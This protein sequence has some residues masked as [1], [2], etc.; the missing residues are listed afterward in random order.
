MKREDLAA[1]GLTDEQIEK[2]IA[3]NG[4][5][6]QTANAKATKNNAELERLQGIE[7]EFNAMKDQNLSEQE[8][9]AKQLEEA[10]KRIAE[11][12]K[13]QTLATQR[14]NAADK[15]KITSEQAAKVVKD[16]GSFDFDVLG[17]IISDKETAAAQAKE[18]EIANGST[19]P[20]GG[21]AGGGKNDTKTEAE[22]AAEKIGKT[23]A[24]TNKEA[25]AVV[26]QYL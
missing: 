1:M 16:D 24:G 18:Q 2:V 17:K 8:K 6:V 22:K 23:L 11:L 15:F 9:A 5:D 19:N 12:E 7:K 26:N 4:K 20:G 3:E 14:T 21:S 10:N 25:E 13:A